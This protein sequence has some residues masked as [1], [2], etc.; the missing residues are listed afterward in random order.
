MRIFTE[1]LRFSYRS[2][3][4]LRGI[5]VDE[6]RPGELTALIGPNAAGKSTFLRCLAGLHSGTG[7]VAIGG[8]P[9]SAIPPRERTRTVSY[10]PQ[11][12]PGAAALTVFEA[13]LVAHRQTR[14]GWRLHDDDLAAV[15]SI[16]DRLGLT[17]LAD[18]NL[19]ELSGGQRQLVAVAQALVTEPE[20]L[21]LD[22]PTSALDLHHQLELLTLVRE[23]AR[24]R[25]MSVLIAI[26]DLNLAARFASRILVL[27]HGSVTA[28]GTPTEVL[29]A[30]ML[31]T[32]YRV[33]VRVLDDEGIPLVV[34]LE[35]LPAPEAVA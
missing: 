18:R 28:A 8:R 32:V 6:D 22:E 24:E 11:D 3:E 31:R 10:L 14:P 2:R 26:H 23:L 7:T 19:G 25:N 21:L 15:G 20:V 5:D 12:L 13:V 4:V 33:H 17:G 29:T 16:V 35:H 27:H 34:P 1:D 30:E 9:I